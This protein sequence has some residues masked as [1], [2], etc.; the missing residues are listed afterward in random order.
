MTITERIEELRH[1]YIES[2][3]AELLI[4]NVKIAYPNPYLKTVCLKVL[5]YSSDLSESFSKTAQDLINKIPDGCI[6]DGFGI[7]YGKSLVK[8]IG[9]H[10][11]FAYVYIQEESVYID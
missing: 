7:S 10:P 3:K 6:I 11:T 8:I 4:K 1:D 5:N 2:I 9:E